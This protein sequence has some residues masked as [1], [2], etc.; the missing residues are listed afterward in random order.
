MTMYNPN[1]LF[2]YVLQPVYLFLHLK[3]SQ[4]N[5]SVPSSPIDP[6]K[7]VRK[8]LSINGE[9]I[10]AAN[11]EEVNIHDFAV[12]EQEQALLPEFKNSVRLKSRNTS[13]SDLDPKKSIERKTSFQEIAKQVVNMEKV[14]LR[15]PNPKLRPRTRHHSSSSEDD[16]GGTTDTDT[17]SKGSMGH[18]E[19]K[20]DKGSVHTSTSDISTTD[21]CGGGGSPHHVVVHDDVVLS[22]LSNKHEHD[23]GKGDGAPVSEASLDKS[24][25]VLKNGNDK[26]EEDMKSKE[27]SCCPC[28]LL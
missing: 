15:W 19:G 8:S 10:S 6:N 26:A 3:R 5:S 21:P 12:F 13:S 2:F 18:L 22:V 27:Q 17:C 1:I 28:V 25:S 4:G 16:D 7:S 23:L 24:T 14:L 20:E 11:M 9:V